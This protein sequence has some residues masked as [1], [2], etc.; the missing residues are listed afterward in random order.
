MSLTSKYSISNITFEDEPSV[1]WSK[2]DLLSRF[3]VGDDTSQV[4]N[5]FNTADLIDAKGGNDT[6]D[7][8]G[9]N[10]MLVG[11]LGDDSLDGGADNDNLSGDEGNDSLIGG[12]GFDTLIGGLGDD[13]LDGGADNDSLLGGAGSDTL[14]G[15]AGVDTLIGGLGDDTYDVDNQSDV[16]TEA[17]GLD[18]DSVFASTSYT[19]PDNIDYAEL[20]GTGNFT[21][22]GNNQ[23]MELHGNTG[24]N[25]LNGGNGEDTIYGE[26]GADTLQ[27]GLGDDTYFVKSQ[28]DVIV[29]T[30]TGGRDSVWT[31]VDNTRLAEN[32]ET[33]YMAGN[34]AL[35]GLGSSGANK[36]YG[37]AKANTIFGM[38]GN[39]KLYGANGNDTL[40]GGAGDDALYGGDGNDTFVY[41]PGDGYD[42]IFSFDATGNDTLVIRGASESQIWLAM[43]GTDL[44]ISVIGQDGAVTVSLWTGGKDWQLDSIKLDQTGKVLTR[45]K[46]D[47]LVQAMAAFTP[48]D[49]GQTTLPANYQAALNNVIASSWA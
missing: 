32:T 38:A 1:V 22:T 39:D 43:D 41:G 46:I 49:I 47:G 42:R 21:L 25:I 45:D 20:T 19:V 40:L 33:L 29:E 31:Y 4:L 48:P 8:N 27:G 37:N 14:I 44:D 7:G 24:N 12:I 9:G 3:S 17:A 11:G 6:I 15:G 23:G 16:I 5:G 30:A 34:A 28:G 18:Y 35:T 2:A 10:D 13:S 36:L 26:A